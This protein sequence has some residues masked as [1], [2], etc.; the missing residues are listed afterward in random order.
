MADSD[1]HRP[2]GARFGDLAPRIVVGVALIALALAAD[3]AGGW[4]FNV[5]VAAATMLVFGEWCSMHGSGG[6]TRAA[7]LAVLAAAA[8]V[9]G[10]ALPGVALVVVAV[11]AAVLFA[12]DRLGAGGVLYAGLPAVALIWLRQLPQ[13]AELVIWTLALV[14]ATDICAYFAGRLIGGPRI[15]PAISPSKTWAGLAGGM[16]GAGTTA[17]L[18]ADALGLQPAVARAALA[19]ALLAVVAQAGDFFESHLKRRA[20]VKDS[21][22][23]LPGHGGVMDRLD[24][25][26]PVA[27]VVALWQRLAA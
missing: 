6:G 17:A 1:V 2:A 8:L 4:A 5:L 19:G 16:L 13:G 14:W 15:A 9:A 7:G 10:L 24:G 11:T 3:W 12:V 26:I 22:H 23:L 27:V 18:L 25:A 20:G 21:S